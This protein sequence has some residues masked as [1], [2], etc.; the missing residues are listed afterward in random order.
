[1]MER[2]LVNILR[3]ALKDITLHKRHGFRLGL[4][5]EV[6]M[7]TGD[8]L[9]DYKKSCD[10]SSDAPFE[11]L[12]KKYNRY[13]SPQAW[14]AIGDRIGVDTIRLDY[15]KR[16]KKA[17][18][19]VCNHFKFLHCTSS[20]ICDCQDGVV[21]D[22]A[23]EA[24]AI[25]HSFRCDDY[26][27]K[28]FKVKRVSST[29]TFTHSFFAPSN[30]DCEGINKCEPLLRVGY[31]CVLQ[32]SLAEL[33]KLQL[34]FEKKFSLEV[35]EACNVQEHEELIKTANAF[36]WGTTKTFTDAKTQVEAII[37]K[38]IQYCRIRQYSAC[39]DNKCICIPPTT[40]TPSQSDPTLIT[41]G[42]P[43]NWKCDAAHKSEL[44]LALDKLHLPIDP[45][46]D[47]AL[48]AQN[49]LF[50]KVD[51]ACTKHSYLPG[52]GGGASICSC[53]EG[54]YGEACDKDS[55]H[56][57]AHLDVY[58]L[59]YSMFNAEGVR[60]ISELHDPLSQ[61]EAVM[62]LDYDTLCA[63]STDQELAQIMDFLGKV[64][65][66]CGCLWKAD[67][68]D[69]TKGSWKCLIG[70]CQ[71]NSNNFQKSNFEALLRVSKDGRILG[72]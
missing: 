12:L 32:N 48:Q 14:M 40:A 57:L 41:C 65:G 23:K 26:E 55:S 62:T 7:K 10:P 31:F 36:N 61:L 45:D 25:K 15:Q 8:L 42:I 43:Y 38:P 1:M 59:P 60:I 49:H 51:I 52:P 44:H 5:L 46:T 30:V 56:H 33:S 27:T 72:I 28:E 63:P 67:T 3:L 58:Y 66:E 24:C 69:K 34:E 17:G 21:Y 11:A 20:R 6:H 16:L 22:T 18:I 71:D 54:Q 50:C 2:E 35:N 37:A 29:T 9:Q 13:E 19:K 68:T 53:P 47:I 4:S 39:Q 64:R 70:P